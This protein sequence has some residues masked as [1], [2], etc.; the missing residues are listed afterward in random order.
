MYLNNGFKPPVKAKAYQRA[1]AS[2]H[3]YAGAA[4]SASRLM[5]CPDVRAARAWHYA[6]VSYEV[7]VEPMPPTR[8]GIKARLIECGSWRARRL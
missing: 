7:P 8:Q 5:R 3:S 6:C 4:V 1:F 2:A